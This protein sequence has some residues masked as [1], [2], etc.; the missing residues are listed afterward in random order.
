MVQADLDDF[1]AIIAF[2]GWKY[3]F[4]GYV[5]RSFYIGDVAEIHEDDFLV[6]L[7]WKARRFSGLP[8]FKSFALPHVLTGP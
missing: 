6:Y 1:E 8:K 5:L 4:T 3:G 2:N 7:E